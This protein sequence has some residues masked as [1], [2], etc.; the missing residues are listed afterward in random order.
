MAD[1]APT[2]APLPQTEPASQTRTMTITAYS[3]SPDETDDTPFLTASNTRT[4]DGIVASNDL[5][6]GATVR[7]PEHFGQKL[8]TV[9]DRMHRRHKNRIDVWFPS[10]REALKF[11]VAHAAVVEVQ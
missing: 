2:A 1:I 8:F 9:E 6:F 5:P 3:S 7:I 11:G 4:R 10:K